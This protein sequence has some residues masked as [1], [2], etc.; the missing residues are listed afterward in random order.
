MSA[1]DRNYFTE[2]EKTCRE[3]VAADPSELNIMRII[4]SQFRISE[5][6]VSLFQ[7][8]ESFFF[9]KIP[10]TFFNVFFLKISKNMFFCEN[11]QKHFFYF[12]SFLVSST[13]AK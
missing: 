7:N 10:K 8:F 2:L 13:I 5:L 3:E 9:L 1:N 11:F 6:T 4:V 12:I